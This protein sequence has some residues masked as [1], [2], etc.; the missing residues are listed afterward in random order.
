MSR[1]LRLGISVVLLLVVTDSFARKPE[2]PVAYT[3]APV[4]SA[5]DHAA[6]A[7]RVLAA[8][9]LQS[10]TFDNGSGGPDAQGWTTFDR[11]GQ[12]AYF[13][14]DSYGAIAGPRGLWCGAAVCATPELCDYLSLPGYG[15]RWEQR[16]QSIPFAV[17]GANVTVGF[18][19]NYDTE[20]SYDLIYLEYK[21]A[22]SAWQQLGSWSGIGST[23]VTRVVDAGTYTSPLTF[24]IRFKSD[25]VISDEDGQYNSNGAAFIDDLYVT[26]NAT[27]IDG[28]SFTA[29]SVGATA[30]VD[31]HWQALAQPAFGDYAALFDGDG[32]LQQDPGVANP[33]HL[34]GFFNGSPD[35]YSC[36]GFP[37]QAVVPFGSFVEGIPNFIRNEIR[38]PTVSLAGLTGTEPV[39]L[40][41]DVYMDSPLDNLVAWH[42]R[43]RSRVGGVWKPWRG[44]P[45]SY[46]N[47]NKLWV[48]PSYNL[49]PLILAGAT[50]IE[51]AIGVIDAC[52]IWCGSV[53][54]G[55]CHS[56]GPLID[57]V[58]LTRSNTSTG[59]GVTVQPV[60]PTTGTTPVTLYFSNV[61]APGLTTLVTGPAGPAVPGSFLLGNSLYYNISTTATTTGFIDVCITYNEG[62]LTVPE[63]ALRL[64]HW[65][66]N[67]NPDAWVDITSGLDTNANVVCGL[68][69]HLSPF[70]LG[71]GS[72]TG[73]EGRGM[74][75]KLA[76]GQNVPNP[77]NP[78]TSISY[79]VPA[80]G[81][82]VTIRVHDVA[83]RLVR[84]LVDDRRPTGTHDVTWDGRNTAG[85]PV[86]S[87][88]YFYRMVAGSF[89]EA[90]RM[91]L[92][93]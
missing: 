21:D 43:V 85:A 42:H 66:T 19:M 46:Y 12:P 64:L 50:D 20:P 11:T 26:D 65:D 80:G 2:P 33:T 91:V 63:S 32:V 72:V 3:P 89:T 84:T 49:R 78:I 39:M 45:V 44:H 16:F 87:G 27:D 68:T 51:V 9:V 41:F 14:V 67:L 88:V 53:G 10:W 55:A 47:P 62:A 4:K 58:S 38:S 48:H 1:T 75:K 57:N 54:T 37:G 18:T 86:S 81:A 56:H 34:W 82:H 36:G 6:L 29:E 35:N 22:T 25:G 69:N 76:L 79:D 8:D 74:P 17:S 83:G 40:T 28:H 5:G 93:K 73:V 77:F 30:T 15:N 31:G 60:D 92:L 13:H 59:P 61:T 52:D 70:V 90:R 71:A 7:P 23:S 24:R